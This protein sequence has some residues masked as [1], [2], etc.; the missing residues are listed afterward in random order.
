MSRGWEEMQVVEE[1][2]TRPQISQRT[3]LT[4]VLRTIQLALGFTVL[5]LTGYA[6]S[7]FQGD[8]FHTFALAF[9]SFV[10]TVLLLILIF[11][12]PRWLPKWN[13]YWCRLTVELI[14]CIFWLSSFSLLIWECMDGDAAFAIF[15]E[16][17][18]PQFVAYVTASK[19]K[20]AIIGLKVAIGLACI[21]WI[22]FAVT[23]IMATRRVSE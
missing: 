9:V 12:M 15:R 10:W 20:S 14:T 4:A 22:L 21:N 17:G 16:S 19:V 23:F 2:E 6:A 3:V 5:F 11:V 1:T 13:V 18:E 8:F 7:I